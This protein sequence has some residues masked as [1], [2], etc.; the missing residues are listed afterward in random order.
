MHRD[1]RTAAGA[2]RRPGAE[3]RATAQT[4]VGWVWGHSND[5]TYSNNHPQYSKNALR[6]ETQVHSL[7]MAPRLYAVRSAARERQFQSPHHVERPLRC[8]GQ[9]GLPEHHVAKVF[10]IPREA[11]P[12]RRHSARLVRSDEL[13]V[14]LLRLAVPIGF[15]RRTALLERVFLRIHAVLDERAL[16]PVHDPCRPSGGGRRQ[17]RCAQHRPR[18]SIVQRHVERVVNPGAVA[19]DANIGADRFRNS[20]EEQCLIEQMRPDVEPDPGSW[21][22]VLAPGA[23]L[24]FRAEP[25]EVRFE[26]HDAAERTLGDHLLYR[27]EIAG[28]AAILVHADDALLLF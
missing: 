12:Q 22:G 28:V 10:I 7:F 3:S 18:V 21:Q 24:S 2:K 14:Q 1:A 11:R 6:L 26:Q 25:I 17:H 20:K 23:W 4:G 13:T 8:N 27:R 5:T 16:G 19:L 9:L 15:V